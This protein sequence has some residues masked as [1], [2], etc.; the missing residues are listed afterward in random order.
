MLYQVLVLLTGRANELFQHH[1]PASSVD[2]LEVHWLPSEVYASCP[3]F[4]T[5]H[6]RPKV[7]SEHHRKNWKTSLSSVEYS[8]LVL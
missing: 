6:Y 1:L 8:K 2:L 5:R 7:E 4:G 3:C